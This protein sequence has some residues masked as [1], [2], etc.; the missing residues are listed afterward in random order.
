MS[1]LARASA[2]GRV[3]ILMARS[4][5]NVLERNYSE[6]S[7]EAKSIA[8]SANHHFFHLRFVPPRGARWTR[9]FPTRS[10]GCDRSKSN[11][12]ILCDEV[13]GDSAQK[14]CLTRDRDVLV[15]DVLQRFV[16]AREADRTVSWNASRKTVEVMLPSDPKVVV[17]SLFASDNGVVRYF[18]SGTTQV[19]NF[20]E[21]PLDSPVA[22][23]HLLAGVGK[24]AF[25]YSVRVLLAPPPK[26]PSLAVAIGQ[27]E[28]RVGQMPSGHWYALEA[29][30]L[31]SSEATMVK[32]A[33]SHD[34][35][36]AVV[37]VEPVSACASLASRTR[38]FS[39]VRS[40]RLGRGRRRS[41]DRRQSR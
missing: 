10:P 5:E 35:L 17:P 32:Q 20:W 9:P 21:L 36:H 15:L 3:F 26:N 31:T 41:P 22:S 28:V 18:P 7:R 13:L 6:V 39:L 4:Y 34:S 38:L 12:T 8:R 24:D 11:G 19:P 27:R 14:K 23:A 40:P 30:N 29:R 37:V 16:E 25:V 2:R 33:W 1:A